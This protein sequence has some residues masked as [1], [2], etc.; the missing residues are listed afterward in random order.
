MPVA[1]RVYTT[2]PNYAT[3]SPRFLQEKN[4]FEAIA[5]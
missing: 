3:R 2:D 4:V 5:A 1:A